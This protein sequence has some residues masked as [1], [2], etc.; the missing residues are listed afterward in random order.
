LQA[1]AKANIRTRTIA[2]IRSRIHADD[3]VFI[4]SR[5]VSLPIEYGWKYNK[6]LFA[7]TIFRELL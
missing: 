1:R 6:I 2:G 7:A 4:C 3:H 5:T